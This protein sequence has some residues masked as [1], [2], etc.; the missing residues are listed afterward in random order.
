MAYNFTGKE[1][2][3]STGFYYFGARYFDPRANIWISPDPILGDYLDGQRSRGGVFNPTNLNLFAY[4]HM[5]PVNLV[6]LNGLEIGEVNVSRRVESAI[7]ILKSTKTGG[8]LWSKMSE[9]RVIVNIGSHEGNIVRTYWYDKDGKLSGNFDKVE[10][11]RVSIGEGAVTSR[12]M[13]I[14]RNDETVVFVPSL[15]RSL[16][17]EFGHT[18]GESDDGGYRLADIFNS[19]RFNTYRMNNISKW[20]NPIMKELGS[21]IERTSYT[22][23]RGPFE[24]IKPRLKEDSVNSNPIKD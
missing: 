3:E 16:A 24:P 11:V 12:L 5:Q 14:E 17:H 22:G 7:G 23:R 20:E 4:G 8:E 6:D 21:N 10:T 9:S 2:D 15:V 1:L 19:P 13:G 18:I